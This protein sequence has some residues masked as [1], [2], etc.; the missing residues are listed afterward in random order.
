MTRAGGRDSSRAD[1]RP[2]SAAGSE[3][4]VCIVGGGLVGASLACALEPLGLRVALLEAVAPR[5]ATQPSYDD[6]TLA[7]SAS[8]CRILQALGIWPLLEE[9][10]TPIR[11]IHV[12][13]L[14][15]PGRVILRADELG[16]DCYGNVVEARVFGAAAQRLLPE[17]HGFEWLCPARLTTLTPDDEAVTV[18]YEADGQSAELRCR[19]VVGADGAASA[20]R[21]ALGIETRHH[22]YGQ[23]AVIC[24]VTP[25]QH[26]AGR[27][28]ERLSATGPFAILPH[29]GGRCGLVW[30][31]ETAQA[32]SLLD[33]D[34]ETFLSRA[35]SRFGDALGDWTR[36]GRRSAYPLQL[37]RPLRDVG[38]RS[39][40]LGNAAHAI[41]PVGAQ[42]FNLGLR[43]V[44]VLA[45]VIAD[46]LARDRGADPGEPDLLRRYSE[47]RAPDQDRTIALTD[48]LAR[49]FANPTAGAA[50]ARR[51]GLLAHALFPGLRRRLAV[52]AMGYR[53]RIPRLALGE[54]LGAG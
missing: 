48:G 3:A 30:S 7:L 41:H 32:R 40:L 35:R 16:L 28:F 45:E 20:V 43:D 31:V 27:A 13:E 23:T 10:A 1:A 52:Q 8:S 53:G 9:N 18:G 24:N 22:D 25:E 4:D 11:E 19:L 26:H 17:L 15:R 37:T 14:G 5:S 39:L 44:A 6:R 34:D 33:L 46:A 12:S 2:D 51:A 21:D 47:W 49:L 36:V 50:A 54:D 42:G 38:P 29:V